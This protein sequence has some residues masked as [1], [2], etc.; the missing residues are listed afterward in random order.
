[1][2]GA[3]AAGN[4]RVKKQHLKAL[5]SFIIRELHSPPQSYYSHPERTTNASSSPADVTIAH[6]AQCLVPAELI[7]HGYKDKAYVARP[8]L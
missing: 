3:S 2:T 5:F 1:M 6:N 8:P 7:C 4:M